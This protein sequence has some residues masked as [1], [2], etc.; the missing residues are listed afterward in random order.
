MDPITVRLLIGAA[1]AIAA[2]Q[3]VLGL[4]VRGLSLRLHR[5]AVL[6]GLAL[7]VVIVA[8]YAVSGHLLI[9]TTALSDNIPDAPA[10]TAAARHGVLNDAVFQFIPWEVEVRRAYASRRLPLWSDSLDGGSSPWSNPQAGAASPIAMAARLAPVEHHLLAALAV[11]LLV[12]FQG[13]WLLARL[14]GCRRSLCGLAGL[15][16]ALGGGIMAWSLFAHSSTAA[17]IPWLAAGSIRTTRRP[18]PKH[19]V[20]TAAITAAMLLS[21]HPETMLGGGALAAVCALCFGRR[22]RGLRGLVRGAAA[23]TGAAALGFALAAPHVLP[24]GQLLPHTV[25]YHEMKLSADASQTS[26]RPLFHPL[27][28]SA[29]KGATNPQVTGAYP[30]AGTA[31]ESHPYAGSGYIPQAGACYAGLVALA[32]AAMAVVTRRR[33]CWPFL[34]VAA[35]IAFAL[36]ELRPLMWALDRLPLTGS[37]TWMQLETTI[38]LCLAVCGAVGLTELLRRRR[39]VSLLGAV[40]A[41]AVSIAMFASPV[42]LVLWLGVLAATLLMAWRPGAGAVAL[43]VVSLMDL[44][45][46]AGAS[47]PRG[48]RALFYPD[49]GFMTALQGE[50][51]ASGSC[52]VVGYDFAIYPSLLAVYGID[53]IRYHNPVADFRYAHLLGRVFEFHREDA[54]YE[55]FSAFRHLDRRLLDFLNV[56]VVVSGKTKI[57]ARFQEMPGDWESRLRIY[58]NRRVLP[59]AFIPVDAVIVDSPR[60]ASAVVENTDFRRVVLDRSEIQGPP[61]GRRP[62]SPR[63]VT[64]TTVTPGRVHLEVRGGG[65]RLV[66]TSLTHPEGWSARATGRSLQTVTVNH[67]F[68][69]VIVP[70]P[71]RQVTLSYVPP[72]FRGGVALA[73]AGMVV[74]IGSLCWRRPRRRR[75][76]PSR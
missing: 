28:W 20:T 12:A 39:L 17:W 31:T 16:F 67:A 32:G 61:A 48:D 26:P 40:G 66:A 8:T 73:A 15:A 35:G 29:I 30:Y 70:P 53:D 62:W 76:V 49:T 9:P 1:V 19:L 69:G 4:M 25:R 14:L 64:W 5:S 21:G 65:E 45:P 7:A 44:V 36:A 11:K 54:A 50:V 27:S 6:F 56:G 47:L 68:L 72:G 23:A 42:V 60:T 75:P 10:S 63:A 13:A 74:A 43:T 58:R 57:P 18:T 22:S 34:G 3:V 38:P 52:R 24:F 41:A 33:R 55:Y 37:V 71:A 51:E 59:R 2:T 46:W